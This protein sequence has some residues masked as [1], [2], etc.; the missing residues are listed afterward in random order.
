MLRFTR[1]LACALSLSVG[2]TGLRAAEALKVGD[3]APEFVM[4]GSDGKTYAAKDFLDKQ[5]VIVAWFPKA[6]TGGCT[7][8]CKSM[9]E[10][11]EQLK[12]FNVAY[13][14][15]STDTVKVN[16]DFAKSLDLD[17]P[18]LCDP[19]GQNA[20]MFGVLR[21]GK[22]MAN[23]VTFVI[24]KDGKIAAILDEVS[25]ESHGQDLAKLLKELG[26]ESKASK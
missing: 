19:K 2:F 12:K 16:G 18:I 7:K 5:A 3:K 6:F 23:R 9:K 13:F 11:G 8:E 26:V 10:S 24:G 15:A 21:E 14:T 1:L 25:T 17:Y 20:G 22:N 4:Q